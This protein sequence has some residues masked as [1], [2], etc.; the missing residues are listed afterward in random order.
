MDDIVIGRSALV[1]TR[2]GVAFLLVDGFYPQTHLLFFSFSFS[3]FFFGYTFFF[4][5]FYVA[6]L[7]DSPGLSFAV[8]ENYTFSKYGRPKTDV[9]DLCLRYRVEY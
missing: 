3:F 8:I 6:E 4:F 5:S 1:F 2:G 9:D 7:A